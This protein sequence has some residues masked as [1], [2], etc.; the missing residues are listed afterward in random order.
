MNGQELLM[1]RNKSAYKLSNLPKILWMN[2]DSDLHRKE[3][4]ESQFK[5][6]EIEDHVRISGIDGRDGDVTDL[7][8]GRIPES[9]SMN[10]IGCCLSHLKAIRY[11]IEETNLQEVLILEDDISFETA[12]YWQFTWSEMYSKLPYDYDTVQLTTINPAVVYV[13]LHPRFINDFS[14]AAYLITRHHAEKIYKLHIKDKKYKLDNGVIP[15]A[16]SEDTILH[17]GKG[18]CFPLFVYRLDLGSSIHP[19]H[20][21]IFHR[22]S[23][24]GILNFWSKESYEIDGGL[25]RLMNWHPYEFGLPPGFDVNG[26]IQRSDSAD[27]S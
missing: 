15:R 25:D 17:S 27:P 20:I 11:F 3:H 6:W 22:D 14:A 19:E 23:Y 12:K 5:Y 9:M 4:M 18:Y 13:N 16:V 7:L 8:K 2:L 21:D 10:E 26:P 1:D 24:N